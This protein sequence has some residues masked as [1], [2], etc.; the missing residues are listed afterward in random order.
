MGDR[1]MAVKVEASL[2][3]GAISRRD[4]LK[5]GGMGLTSLGLLG[6]V[7]CGGARAG[8]GG[9]ALSW[10][11]W[12]DT[13]EEAELW[14]DLGDRA[15][16]VYP[17]IESVDLRT[18]TFNSYFTK[19]MTELA[20]GTEADIIGMQ[21][22]RMPGFAARDGLRSLR[23]F[24]ED[25]PDFRYEDYF[26]P[27]RTGL[28]FGGGPYA[29]AYDIGPMILFYN[30]DLFDEAGIP[31]P[32]PT[33]PMT[34]ERFR[35]IA[36]ELTDAGANQYGYVITPGFDSMVPWLWSAG[37]DY[38]NAEK[39]E[40]LLGTAE[41]ISAME[42]LV[43][44]IDEGIVAPIT[45]VAGTFSAADQFNSGKI[46]MF[47]DGP[48][49]IL[50]VRGAAEFDFDIAPIPEGS[51]GSIP[52]A[53]GSGF[54]ISKSVADPEE[55]WQALKVITNTQALED[56]AKAGR[57]YPARRSSVPAF[58]DPSLPPKNVELVQKVLDGEIGEVRPYETTATWEE[59]NV[60]LNRE[61]VPIL[62]G[63]RSV[64]EAVEVVVPQFDILLDQH[65]ELV[66]KS[67]A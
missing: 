9:D 20:A 52:W 64:E 37:G 21:S 53:A 46:G 15:A 34:W 28:S 17:G 18:T 10:S 7:G 29:L 40:C 62:L 1:D 49:S 24:M 43:G 13:P 26:P 31:L 11:M 12:A 16:E 2:A 61:L 66:E 51:A 63:N 8:S 50:T 4:F 59:T 23:Q 65:Q 56:L 57:G 27:I 35:E 36:R 38:M 48:W 54:G 42:F 45:T 67:R 41:S 25:D 19:L 30:K 14:R 44:M 39:T 33:G 22:L 5:L 47:I 6:A 32:S 55:A 60:M 58:E 3:R